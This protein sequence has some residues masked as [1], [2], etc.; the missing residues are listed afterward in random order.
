MK[1]CPKPKITIFFV[2]C[3]ASCELGVGNL[4]RSLY[5]LQYYHDAA[6]PLRLIDEHTKSMCRQFVVLSFFILFQSIYVSID[7][8]A[9]IDA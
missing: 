3:A 9:S 6:N 7:K 1:K 4:P 8:N 2:N 5:I